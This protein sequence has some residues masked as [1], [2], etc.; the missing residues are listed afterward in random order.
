VCNRIAF[1][2][3]HSLG[4]LFAIHAMI[5]KPGL[6]NSYVAVSP[7][8]Q[9]E[10]NEALKRAETYLKNQKES[11][12]TLFASIGNEPARSVMLSTSSKTRLRNQTSRVSSGKLSAWLMKITDRWCFAVTILVCERFLTVGRCHE[13]RQSGAFSGGLKGADAHYKKLSEKFGYSVPRRRT[14]SIRSVTSFSSRLNLKKR[15]LCSRRTSNVIRVCE[16]L[17]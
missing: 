5:A 10:N 12:V 16:R 4:G 3:G 15:S 13:I 14:S 6:F 2:A 17:R 7:S 1:F 9:W 8:L 11:K